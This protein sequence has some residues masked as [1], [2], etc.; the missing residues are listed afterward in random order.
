MVINLGPYIK[1]I[2]K[3]VIEFGNAHGFPIFSVPWRIHM[4]NIMRE[5]TRQIHMDGMKEIEIET[6]LKN[7]IFLP[8]NTELYLPVLKK[9]G[10]KKEWLYCVA[11]IDIQDRKGRYPKPE[12]LK[13][14]VHFSTDF[15]RLHQRHAVVIE[16][17]R[18]LVILF[19]NMAESKIKERTADFINRLQCKPFSGFQLSCYIGI[20]QAANSVCGLG[21]CYDQ[22]ERV[23][24]LQKK[25]GKINTTLSYSEIGLYKLLFSVKEEL[26]EEYY[27]ETLG[28]LQSY[29]HMNETDYLYFLKKYFELGCSIQ[30]AAAELHLHRNSVAYKLRKIEEII[31]LSVNAPY[32]RTKI[33]VALMI[34]EIR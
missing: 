11:A 27:A 30:D 14:L 19:C 12:L 15:F 32:D 8:E 10:Y 26:L 34:Q 16:N 7:A 9:H 13:K 25:R 6:A 18:G 22:A 28:R 23:K 24:S 3:K 29:D 31:K 4:A 20:G 5:F 21:E 17:D 2:P 33:M 1:E